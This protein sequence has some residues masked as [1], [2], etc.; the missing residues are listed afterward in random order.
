MSRSSLVHLRDITIAAVVVFG[1]SLAPFPHSV[2]G[3]STAI[4]AN[5]QGTLLMV[6]DS[7]TVGTDYFGK[8]QSRIERLSIWTTVS[9][10][11]KDGR[12]ASQ[13]APIL[14]K[15][16]TPDTTAIVIA[17]GTNDM[18]SKPETWYPRW[19]ID[20]VMQKTRGL[21]VLWVNLEFSQTGRSDWRARGVRFNRELRLAALRYPNLKI[22]D[23]NSAFTPKSKSRFITDGVHLTVSGYITRSNFMVPTISSFGISVVNASTT[24]STT[25][26]TTT[27]TTTSPPTT[28]TI[29][30]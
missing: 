14:H 25:S 27:S 23:W 22:A 15:H 21:P 3:R 24:T 2:Q 1:L 18:I 20:T 13:A 5:G 17:L 28:T 16:L 4:G 8:L 6:G 9:I 12:K 11:D 7:L 19:V 26:T 30:S 10:D 29:V